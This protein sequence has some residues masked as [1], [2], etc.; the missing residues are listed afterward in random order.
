MITKRVLE[1]ASTYFRYSVSF[2]VLSRFLVPLI[3]TLVKVRSNLSPDTPVSQRI[4]D[5]D[6]LNQINTF[7][8]AGS[9]TTSLA[10]GWTLHI[11]SERSD[12]Q[13]RLR[14]ELSTLRKHQPS[15]DDLFHS[16]S[17]PHSHSPS[18][19]FFS[20]I[21]KLP[22]LDA[23]CRES[24]RLVPPVHGT[25]RVAKRDDF[26]PISEPLRYE[27]RPRSWSWFWSGGKELVEVEG[28]S[29]K[30]GEYVHIPIEGL[31]LAKQVWGEDAHEFK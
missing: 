6:I 5:E 29:I 24:L 2:F 17:H 15:N 7:L 1:N 16:H 8:F 9:D 3:S 28:I 12:V 14:D 13:T 26:I 25:I 20:L 30:K 22:F 18:D 4:K 11:L 31:N 27:K 23:V 10:V 19:A 21:D